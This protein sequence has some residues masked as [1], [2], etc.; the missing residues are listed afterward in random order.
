[1]KKLTFALFVFLGVTAAGSRAGEVQ[2]V[3]DNVDRRYN[4]L[5]TLTTDFTETYKG[6]GMQRTESGTLA[7]K[8]P[9][10]MR[11]DYLQPR[12]K[13][14]VT[15]GKKA[16][17]YVPGE[18]QARQA[19]MKKLDDLRSPLRYLLGKTRLQ[20]EFEGLTLADV[21]PAQAGDVVLQG[22]P[23]GMADRVRRVLL[24]V[25]PDGSIHRIVA[26][27]VDGSTTEFCFSNQR[28][29]VA[30]PD[31]KFQFHVPPGVEIIQAE[32]VGEY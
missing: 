23:R 9:G 1:M 29:D 17:F 22:V 18:P 7:L 26:E 32:D 6:A 15:D 2:R 31:A 13:L 8:K 14:F 30:L 3:A 10:K 19:P 28:E 16:Y 11:W 27:E 21:V 12:E 20:K 5:S 25:G 4:R 24:E